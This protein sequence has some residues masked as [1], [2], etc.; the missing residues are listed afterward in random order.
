ML[1]VLGNQLLKI[2]LLSKI[3]ALLK[4]FFTNISNVI[5]IRI[6]HATTTNVH[7]TSL[8]Q[9]R[10]ETT[11]KEREHLK[12]EVGRTLQSSSICGDFKNGEIV[13]EQYADYD[14]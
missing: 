13:D 8:E 2:V 10:Y 4:I 5:N 11:G 9:L 14:M 1:F 7:C 6:L 3:I 12:K